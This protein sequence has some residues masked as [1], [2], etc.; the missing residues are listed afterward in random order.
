MKRWSEQSYGCITVTIP[1]EETL[2]KEFK[3][4]TL[5]ERFNA[6]CLAVT[7]YAKVNNLSQPMLSDILNGK[8]KTTAK[9][10]TKKGSARKIYAQLK[11]DDI[12]I[13]ALPWED[14]VC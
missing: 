4:M 14:V 10:Q 13:G 2:K 11:K 3:D 5:R 7:K 9:R 6:K 8:S 12:Y 1:K